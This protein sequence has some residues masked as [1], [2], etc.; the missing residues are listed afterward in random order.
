MKKTFFLLAL[1]SV[2]GIVI[3]FMMRGTIDDEPGT[4]IK[5]IKD[6]RLVAMV[7]SIEM[8]DWKNN[9]QYRR[10]QTEIGM[11]E[12]NGKIDSKDKNL[13]LTTLDT[14]YAISLTKKYNAIKTTFTSFPSALFNEM[15]A[16]QSKNSDLPTG[17]RE[18]RAFIQLQN[19]ES[20]INQFINGRYSRTK[21]TSIRT[22]INEIPIGS[23]SSNTL[24]IKMKSSYFQKLGSFQKDVETVTDLI[25]T[26]EKYP[27]DY[28]KYKELSDWKDVSYVLKYPYYK[29]W[30]NNPNNN[31]FL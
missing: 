1:F 27:D 13:L 6:Q 25:E 21:S 8:A 30:F 26:A 10:V 5:N 23:L 15:V 3:Y 20:S 4:D 18:L 11:S 12:S 7:D 31:R 22:Q 9:A 17:V 14:K 29:A 16:F 24:C 19:I 2:A 28:S